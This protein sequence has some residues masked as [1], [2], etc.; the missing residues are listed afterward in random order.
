MAR[1]CHKHRKQTKSWHQEEET[2]K[3]DITARI[4]SR[5]PDKIAY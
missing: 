3:T 5:P 1:K 4:Q 2:M